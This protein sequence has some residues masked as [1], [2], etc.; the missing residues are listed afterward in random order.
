MIPDHP[1]EFIAPADPDHPACFIKIH[2]PFAGTEHFVN[3]VERRGFVLQRDVQSVVLL[4]MGYVDR[5]APVLDRPAFRIT[6]QEPPAAKPAYRTVLFAEA[7][8]IARC[9]CNVLIINAGRR[10]SDKSLPVFR[11]NPA[12]E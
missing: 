9:A 12:Q 6:G 4:L 1:P 7:K 3:R 2:G 8:I 11:I 5:H 10:F